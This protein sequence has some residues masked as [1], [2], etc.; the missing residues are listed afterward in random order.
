MTQ[1]KV[2]RITPDTKRVGCVRLEKG[3]RQLLMGGVIVY[4]HH[5]DTFVLIAYPTPENIEEAR[6]SL[7]TERDT[8]ADWATKKINRGSK[9]SQ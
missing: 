7:Y 8:R 5:D 2:Y 9:Y 4:D 1:V 6:E 3:T